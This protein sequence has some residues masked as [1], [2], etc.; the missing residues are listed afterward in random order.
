MVIFHVIDN[1]KR[2]GAETL[3]VQVVKSLAGHRNYII[4]L[5]KDNDF[6]AEALQ[7]TELISLDFT[8]TLT[9]FKTVSKLKKLIT[10]LRPQVVH[11]H[12]PF[13]SSIARIATPR[14]IKL[15][16][17]VHNKYSESLR[18]KSWK[19]F[20]L[21]KRLHSRRETLIFVSS[22][23]RDDYQA[24]IGIKCSSTVLHNFIRDEFFEVANTRHADGKLP[25]AYRFVG[26]GSLKQQKNF[27]SLIKAFA[28]LKEW[29]LELDIYGDGPERA[30]LAELIESN[31]LRNVRLQGVEANIDKL[32]PNF[33]AFVL[34]S[35]YEGFGLAPLE[36]AAMGLPLL[37]SDIDVFREVTEGYA[38]FFSPTDINDI[39]SKIDFLCKN[40][41]AACQTAERFKHIVKDK[42]SRNK[43]MHQL[44]KIY[45]L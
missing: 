41:Q 8:S 26:V 30:Q 4:T 19:M 21:E 31:G 15:F 16:I 39:A 14:H 12:L 27:A 22:A 28:L 20:M 43:Y 17:S 36:A 5:T 6:P 13:S 11:A 35:V 9:F 23:I 44:L 38:I 33:D 1:L 40:Y 29:D 45:N 25:R 7:G 18:K 32:L 3:L 2:G 34:P 10:T 42:Y 37:L 24:L